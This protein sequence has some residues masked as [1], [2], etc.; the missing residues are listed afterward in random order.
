MPKK[1]W[2]I[3]KLSY[4]GVHKSQKS[5]L[6]SLQR[7][8]ERYEMSNLEI[9]ERYFSH[10]NNIVNKMRIYGEGMLK[11]KVVKKILCIMLIKF[12]HMVSIIIQSHDTNKMTIVELQGS[13]QS[14]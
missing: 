11:N 14:M 13:M 4:E 10:V 2:D 1:A 6:Q 3:L 8:Y 12:D 5:K 9:V 7:E